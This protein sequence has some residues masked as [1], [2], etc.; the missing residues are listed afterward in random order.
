MEL[1]CNGIRAIV[2]AGASGIGRAIAQTLLEQ[3]AK[4]HICDVVPERLAECRQALP[5]ITSSLADVSDPAQVDAMFADAVA[6]LGG[7]DLLVNNAGIA[8]PTGPVE[9]LAA[10]DW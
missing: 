9:S 10:E 6:H 7:L 2:T 4:V 1:T 8:G 3:G 5:A